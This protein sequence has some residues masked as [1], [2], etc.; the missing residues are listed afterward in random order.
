[1]SVRPHGI[2]RESALQ[3][4]TGVVCMACGERT[5]MI[6]PYP[7]TGT[8]PGGK[9]KGGEGTGSCVCPCTTPAW[10]IAFIA[11]MSAK[12]LAGTLPAWQGQDQETD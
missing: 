6:Y 2:T 5:A 3:P 1:M 10:M 11:D 7:L 4:I 8:G 9:L 12:L